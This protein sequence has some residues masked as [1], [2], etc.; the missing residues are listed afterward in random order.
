MLHVVDHA[1]TNRAN[2]EDEADERTV[3]VTVFGGKTEM[4]LNP[5]ASLLDVFKQE[6]VGLWLRDRLPKVDALCV[7][8]ADRRNV[9]WVLVS[10]KP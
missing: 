4:R 9:A 10:V 3:A 7:A 8:I 2:V 5:M 1:G 6:G